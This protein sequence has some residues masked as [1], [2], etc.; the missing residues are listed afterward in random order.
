MIVVLKKGLA[1]EE[2]TDRDPIM[3]SGKLKNRFILT[4]NVTNICLGYFIFYCAFIAFNKTKC[5]YC[6][7]HILLFYFI[8]CSIV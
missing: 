5:I 6:F 1:K 3:T 8:N 7:I 4:Y 2:A